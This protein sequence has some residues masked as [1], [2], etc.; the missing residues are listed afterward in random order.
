[1]NEPVGLC[2]QQHGNG[3]W[4]R[5]TNAILTIA[6]WN[7]RLMLQ[8]GKLVEIA[9]EARKFKIN[10]LAIQEARWPGQGRIGKQ[11]CSVF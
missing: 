8:P 5:K 6:T 2:G 7:V 4:N 11:N 9:D 10:F 3:K 1:L